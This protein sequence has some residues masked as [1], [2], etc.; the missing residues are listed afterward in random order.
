MPYAILS[1]WWPSIALGW[2]ALAGILWRRLGSR[3]WMLAMFL[4]V[5]GLR[6]LLRAF[7]LAL[8]LFPSFHGLFYAHFSPSGYANTLLGSYPETWS[9]TEPLSFLLCALLALSCF[10][11]MARHFSN[12]RAWTIRL[13]AMLVILSVPSILLSRLA[14][15][16]GPM[17]MLLAAV[18]YSEIF[19]G[20]FVALT[21]IFFAVQFRG[22]VGLSANAKNH[23]MITLAYFAGGVAGNSMAAMVSVPERFMGQMLLQAV[24]LFC[25]GAWAW[26]LSEAG[27][28]VPVVEPEAH[29]PAKMES[30][31]N[32]R[33]KALHKTAGRS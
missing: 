1:L 27:E 9:A 16:T 32:A 26:T 20:S 24:A 12:I 13:T 3:F 14:I 11:I 21:I 2:L 8:N 29:G 28:V 30:A 23:S 18:R 4:A 7:V 15:T 31:L 25:Y 5:Q 17:S 19:W 33:L 22:S 6:A 10:Q